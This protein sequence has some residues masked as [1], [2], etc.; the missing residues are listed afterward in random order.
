MNSKQTITYNIESKLSVPEGIALD[1]IHVRV[2]IK[3]VSAGCLIYGWT[4]DGNLGYVE[5]RGTQ[6]DVRLPFV[7]GQVYVKYLEGLEHISISTL[8]WTEGR[9]APRPP[10]VPPEQRH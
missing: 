6:S 1:A 10:I 9:G 3:P 8:G 4:A 5:V 7:N 2:E